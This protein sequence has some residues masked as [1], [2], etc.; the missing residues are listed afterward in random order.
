MRPV[1]YDLRANR[2]VPFVQSFDLEGYDLTAP[3]AAPFFAA[4]IRSPQS[5]V[6]ADDGPTEPVV[7]LPLVTTDDTGIRIMGVRTENGVP[8]TTIRL[9][10]DQLAMKALPR[11]G[12][13]GDDVRL[14]WDL[15]FASVSVVKGYLLFGDFLVLE[16]ATYT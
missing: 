6:V 13:P 3:G 16:R 10:I 15:Q 7:N 14:V 1:R 8:T 12:E 4:Q 2:Y 11:T 5:V 9:F